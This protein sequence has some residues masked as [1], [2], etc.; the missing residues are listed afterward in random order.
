MGKISACSRLEAADEGYFRLQ[1]ELMLSY[2]SDET[3]L[4]SHQRNITA[5]LAAAK[6]PA[7]A[8]E[9]GASTTWAADAAISLLFRQLK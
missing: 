3:V 7:W 6:M 1:V 4:P 5:A 8:A 9:T 2:G